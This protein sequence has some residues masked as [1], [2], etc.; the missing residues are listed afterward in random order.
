MIRKVSII[1]S[2][3][4]MG[5][6]V[7]A[8]EPPPTN[9]PPPVELLEEFTPLP[10]IPVNTYPGGSIG[11]LKYLP[12][13]A[14]VEIGGN[15]RIWH[16]IVEQRSVN[17]NRFGTEAIH[18]TKNVVS[19]TGELNQ[20]VANFYSRKNI[21]ITGDGYSSVREWM[22]TKSFEEQHRFGLKALENVRKGL[23]K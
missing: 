8:L 6:L 19:V 22:N 17:I 15:G 4:L 14:E 3:L 11:L 9:P 23:W 21:R 10:E 2:L 13:G 16:H 20:A 12:D 7:R 5:S 1:L 18:N